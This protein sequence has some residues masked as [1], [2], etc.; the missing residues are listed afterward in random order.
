VQLA[1]EEMCVEFYDPPLLINSLK[2]APWCCNMQQ[3]APDMKCVLYFNLCL[4]VL[5]KVW[6]IGNGQ[7]EYLVF[8]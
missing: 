4:F 2:M 7:Y 5:F 8:K 3:L 1:H 6:N